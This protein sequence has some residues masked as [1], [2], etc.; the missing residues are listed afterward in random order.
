M[1]KDGELVDTLRPEKRI[2]NASGMPMTEAAIDTGLLRRPLR[3]ARRARRQGAQAP[4]ALRVYIKPFV[5]WIWAGCLLMALGGFLALSRPPL[6]RLRSAAKS[7]SAALRR[8]LQA[9]R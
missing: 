7:P 8:S 5:D 6:P 2:Y 1:R 3:L 9:R 4:G